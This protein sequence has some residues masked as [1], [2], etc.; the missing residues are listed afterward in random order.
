MPQPFSS[1][2]RGPGRN[3]QYLFRFDEDYSYLREPSA[4]AAPALPYKFIPLDDTRDSWLT[5]I[6]GERLYYD[7]NNLNVVPSPASSKNEFEARTTVGADMHFGPHYRFYVEGISGQYIGSTAIPGMTTADLGL[8]N[9]FVEIMDQAGGVQYGVRLGRQA[10]W[11]ANGLVICNRDRSNIPITWNGAR[12]YADWGRGRV[13]VFDMVPTIYADNAFAGKLNT[14]LHLYGVYGSFALPAT[15]LAG[16]PLNSSIDP[17]L[18]RY[19]SDNNSYQDGDMLMMERGSMPHF[20]PGADTRNTFGFRYYG[21]LG[22]IDFDYTGA[23]QTGSTAGN[24]VKAWMFSTQTDYVWRNLASQP[25]LGMHFD[26]GSGGA[27]GTP[28]HGQVSTYQPLY[29]LP[30]YYG[31]ELVTSQTNEIDFAPRASINFSHNVSLEASWLFYYRQNQGDAIYNGGAAGYKSFNPYF[32][33]A[34]IRGRYIGNMPDVVLHWRQNRYQIVTVTLSYFMPG[35]AL[36]KIGGT[37]TF[38]AQVQSMMFF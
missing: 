10:L 16:W 21:G 33:T 1:R 7:H 9:A 11:L 20:L 4:T 12:A 35:S 19:T 32:R 15:R 23:L 30:I 34:K 14:G 22:P 13:D 8:Y 38:Y 25:R 5:L 29:Y 36:R 31:D 6:G 37:S 24:R 27:S 2:G 17:F 3:N 26:G 28:G 18:I